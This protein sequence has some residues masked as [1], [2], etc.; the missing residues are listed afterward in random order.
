MNRLRTTANLLYTHPKLSGIGALIG[1]V[2]GLIAAVRSEDLLIRIPGIFCTVIFGLATLWVIRQSLLALAKYLTWKFFAGISCGF[3]LATLVQP[4]IGLPSLSKAIRPVEIIQ[5]SPSNNE[6]LEDP[7]D[8]IEIF[9][10]ED[11]QEAQRNRINVS[12]EPSHRIDMVWIVDPFMTG[13]PEPFNKLLIRSAQYNKEDG[14]KR[15]EY[16][17]TYQLKIDGAALSQPYETQF[18]TPT[19]K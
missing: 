3:I 19:I 18:R 8:D 5:V 9:F 14:L 16:G 17:T 1:T 7:R 4:S 13:L 6:V 10:S 12:I 11:V 15:F 2:L